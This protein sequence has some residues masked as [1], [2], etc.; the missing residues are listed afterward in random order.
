M[1]QPV[2]VWDSWICVLNPSEKTFEKIKP[3]IEEAYQRAKQRFEK[4]IKQKKR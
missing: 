4:R 3:L 2:Y 1:P